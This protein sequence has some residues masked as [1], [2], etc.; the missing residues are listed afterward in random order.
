MDRLPP[1]LI[2]ECLSYI[3]PIN[4]RSLDPICLTIH[5]KLLNNPYWFQLQIEHFYFMKFDDRITYDQCRDEIKKFEVSSVID[6]NKV[7]DV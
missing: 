7:K 5:K 1:Q 4:F 3:E 2:Y 6:G